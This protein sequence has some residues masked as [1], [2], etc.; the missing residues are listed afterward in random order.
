MQL[1][2]KQTAD[3][4]P[5]PEGDV[6]PTPN[7]I[8]AQASRRQFLAASA[9]GGVGALFTDNW[10]TVAA[11]IKGNGAARAARTGSDVGSLF[12]FIESQAVHDHFPLSFLD[13]AYTSL[14]SWK[15]KARSKVFELL[16]YSPPKCDPAA[17]TVERVDCGDYFRERVLFNT[18][19]DLRIPAIVLVPKNA[20]RPLPTIVALHDHG[21]FFLWG[22][23]KLVEM[24]GENPQLKTFR[25]QYY[26]GKS[27]AIELVRQGYL[28]IVIDMFYWGE[29]RMLLDDDS[30]DWRER[31]ASLSR[32][33]IQAFNSRASQAEP[34]VGRTIYAAGFTWPGVMFWD[35]IR[36]VDYLVT[37]P[38]VDK[39]RIA[40]V[41]LSVGGLRSCHLAALDDRIRAAVVVG[42]MASFPYQLKKHIVN[43]I[44]HTKVVPGLYKYL[45]YPDVASLAA[46]TP[47]LVINGKRDGLFQP[48]G[49][50]ASFDKLHAC[51]K[52]AGVPDHVHTS[53]YDTPHE[54]NAAMQQEAWEWLRKWLH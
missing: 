53:W 6:R 15:E 16:H 20:S 36:T 49:V 28:V 4:Q 25:E 44:G 2:Q 47:L 24:P 3:S 7:E 9:L 13:D 54:F 19:P 42:W 21:A 17:E 35:D 45:D 26:G 37:R 50:Q 30:A 22:K 33:R 29:R 14:A 23:E 27:T 12:P 43:T 31:P 10:E 40:C 11:E 38:D 8:H 52:K 39:Q 5:L 1:P 46:P 48:E 32:E 34:L 41:G 51:Y 18:T